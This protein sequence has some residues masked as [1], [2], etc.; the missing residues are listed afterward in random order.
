MRRTGIGLRGKLAAGLLKTEKALAEA[1][2]KFEQE[3]AVI[4]EGERSPK[5]IDPDKIFMIEQRQ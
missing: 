4:T 3:Y 1:A 5:E 2:K